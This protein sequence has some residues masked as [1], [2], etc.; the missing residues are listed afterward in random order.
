LLYFLQQMANQQSKQ[1]MPERTKQ[2]RIVQLQMNPL[3]QLLT[4]VM[5]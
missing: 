5:I 2:L 4:L 3:V 1:L